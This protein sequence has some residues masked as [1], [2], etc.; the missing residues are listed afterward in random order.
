[1]FAVPTGR[2]F[3]GEQIHLIHFVDGK[4]RDHRDWPDYLG[5][6]RQLGEPWPEADGWRSSLSRRDRAEPAFGLH[7]EE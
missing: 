5:T 7:V 3:A 4:I 2:R 1:M 6:Y